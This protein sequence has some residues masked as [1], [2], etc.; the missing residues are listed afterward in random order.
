MPQLFV[1][2]IVESETLG[3]DWGV[4]DLL[5]AEIGERRILYAISRTDETLV[6]LEMSS[7]GTLL[8]SR[9]LAIDGPFEVG[10][11]P[12][13]ELY[14]G[15]LAIA[16]L[17]SSIGQF[18][19]LSADG[20]LGSQYSEA[21]V[22]TLV[23]PLSA[24]DILVTADANGDG[25]TAYGGPSTAMVWVSSLVDND[26]VF[27][28]GVSDATS[29][30]IDGAD[31]LAAVSQSENGVAL[32][33]VGTEGVLSVVDSFGTLDGL[34]INMPSEIKALQRLDE[35]LL[36]IA[37]PG[38]S[39]LSTLRVDTDGTLWLSDHV[40][41]S[42]AT[43][44]QAVSS[45]DTVTVGNFAYVAAG[46][47]DGGISLFT[48]LPGGRLVHLSTFA[49]TASTTLYRVSALS[50]S[51]A[52][53]AL[54]IVGGSAWEAGLTRLSFDLS[55]QGALLLGQ[56]TPIGTA[57]N[58]QLIGTDTGDFLQAG[59]GEDILYDGHGQ[60]TLTGGG[61]ADLFVFALDGMEDLILDFERGSDRLDLSGFDFLYDVS[62]LSITPTTDGAVITFGDEVLRI[63][64]QDGNPLGTSD[65]ANSDVLNLDRPA[66][67]SVSQTLVGGIAADVLNGNSGNDTISGLEGDDLLSGGAGQDVI[68][69]GQ[70]ADTLRGGSGD[71]TV[72]GGAGNDLILGG[73]E[74]DLVTGGEG[75]DTIYGDEIA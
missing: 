7:D 72:N 26:G 50:M 15:A 58:D 70:G 61:D 27:L 2:Q 32:I 51:F 40:L 54:Q 23:A 37:S 44:F 4:S 57:L 43:R 68:F 28:G 14:D 30:R 47:A 69:G 49:D 46:G 21:G 36:V 31:Y 12:A 25:L 5:F 63:V 24:G 16:G 64:S 62:Q 18:V 48:A 55:M 45:V 53:N 39:S 38:S 20:A 34:P 22:G 74:D 19:S 10:S 52:N 9:S 33:E 60:D 65:F 56:N 1:S 59:D 67:L 13:L 75:G 66:L 6:E 42:N 3:L 17:P 41:D 71:D 73:S 11:A 35:T 29:V 8:V